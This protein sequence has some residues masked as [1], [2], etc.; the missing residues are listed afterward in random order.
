MMACA[1]S[2]TFS[3]A[4]VN[5]LVAYPGWNVRVRYFLSLQ[6][7]GQARVAQAQQEVYGNARVREGE[8][9]KMFK[10]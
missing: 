10:K 7:P 3:G 4:V 5:T 9:N 8:V 1:C 6:D 2:D